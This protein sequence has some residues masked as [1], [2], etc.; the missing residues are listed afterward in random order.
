LGRLGHG[1]G[2]ERVSDDEL[3]ASSF[4]SRRLHRI[5]NEHPELVTGVEQLVRYSTAEEA[6]RAQQQNPGHGRQS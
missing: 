6:G 5:A 4:E 1:R 3:G 2:V